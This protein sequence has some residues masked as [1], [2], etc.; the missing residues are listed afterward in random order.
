MGKRVHSV[1]CLSL[2]SLRSLLPVPSDFATSVKIGVS[3]TISCSCELM[4]E[5]L[6][7]VGNAHEIGAEAYGSRAHP[8]PRQAT[9][10]QF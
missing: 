2:P 5:P 6:I 7:G 4:L 10:Q 1:S 8:R 9:V 3:S